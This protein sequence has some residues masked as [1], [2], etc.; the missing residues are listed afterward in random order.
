[1]VARRTNRRTFLKDTVL[2]GTGLLVLGNS[3]SAWSY[4]ANERVNVALVGV[5]GRGHWFVQTMPKLSNVVAMCDVNDRRAA[6]WYRRIPQAKKF[7]D[8]RK[9]LETMAREI[10]AVVVATPD[11]THAVIS[12]AAIRMGKH[13]LCEKPLTHE[14]H[15]ARVLRKLAVEHKVATQMGNQGTASLG[16]RQSVGL[17]QAGALGEVRQ[18]HVWNTGGGP[19]HRRLPSGSQPVPDYLK[20][21]LWLGPTPSRPFH[22]EWL[23][24]RNWREFD[25]GV[26]GNW[27][28]HMMNV[29]FKALKI[30]TLWH[31]D[32]AAKLRPVIRLKPE[33]PDIAKETFPRWASIRYEI[34]P[35]G[36]LPP[37]HLNWYNGGGG[38][39]AMWQ[40]KGV[41]RRLEGL[42]GTSLDWTSDDGDG[43]D[44]WA[45]IL[46]VGTKGRLYAN[47][48]NTTFTLLPKDTFKDFDRERD[49]L[50][51]SRGH[52]AEWLVAC[53]GGPP[54]MSNFNYAG[55]LAEFALLGN[56]ASQCR[57]TIEFDP[58]GMRITNNAA[59]DQA[60]RREYRKGWFL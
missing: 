41:R 55:P 4:S 24:W 2:G 20:W 53:K 37:L 44:D 6:E 16:F 30:D 59:A 12:A 50:P 33:V 27:G 8:F 60:L 45:G 10:D 19:G 52:E 46:L 21:D 22:P 43:W 23:R 54:A 51:R 1:M 35:R 28:C 3:R 15:E 39:Q 38:A 42:L 7:H 26:F 48:H 57:D 32:P 18:V 31:A 9:M 25:T 29:A 17:I 34:P 13:V 40:E 5:S 11:H 36:D 14:V 56:V 49:A 58:L 47:A